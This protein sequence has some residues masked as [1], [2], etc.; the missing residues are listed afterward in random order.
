MNSLDITSLYTNIPIKKCFNLL[1]TH[2]RKM[3][4][5]SS[6]PINILIYNC[7]HISHMTYFRFSN[8]FYK[9]KSGLPMGNPLITVLA[10]VFLK[11]LE[12]SSFKY[13]LPTNTT[14]FKYI[15][16]ILI[17]LPQNIK[18]ENITEKLNLPLTLSI[19]KNQTI[20]YISWT[21]KLSNPNRI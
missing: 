15:D 17:S 11:V 21:S 8:K 12:P 4:F 18:I 5:N 9:Q 7:K 10:S 16:N 2:L 6:L 14:Y 3:K 20:L 1:A 19:K 13:R